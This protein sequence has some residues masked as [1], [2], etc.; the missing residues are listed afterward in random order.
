MEDVTREYVAKIDSKKRLTLRETPF[1]YYHVEHYPDGRILL[2][3]RELTEPLRI[4]ENT[5]SMMDT[6]MENL[7][8][9]V[10]GTAVDLSQFEE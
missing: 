7:K 5:L 2:Q 8:N 4:S 9:G 1:E 6:S 3:P 10:T